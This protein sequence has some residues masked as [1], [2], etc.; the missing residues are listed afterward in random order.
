[1]VGMVLV[2]TI[3][4]W[5]HWRVLAGCCTVF[6]VLSMVLLFFIPESPSWLVTQGIYNQHCRRG[7]NASPGRLVEAR[8]AL[9][10][11]RGA[12]FDITEELDKLE[13]SFQVTRVNQ[14]KV[15]EK[16]FKGFIR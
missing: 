9:Q 8:K 16:G 4:K 1:M 15:A 10:W 3:G 14:D 12:D 13:K 6:P 7:T 11:L 5:V 2:F